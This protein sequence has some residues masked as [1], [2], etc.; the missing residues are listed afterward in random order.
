M[1]FMGFCYA[2]GTS[3]PLL[4]KLTVNKNKPDTL[5]NYFN[6]KTNNRII[7][8]IKADCFVSKEKLIY[9]FVIVFYICN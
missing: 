2:G 4:D 1:I 7:L 9:V 5:I 3:N 8:S 6:S